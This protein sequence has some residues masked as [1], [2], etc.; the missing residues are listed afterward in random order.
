MGAQ[1]PK[2]GRF[3]FDSITKGMYENPLCIFR[4]YIQNSADSLDKAFQAKEMERAEAQI[5]IEIKPGTSTITVE[6][7]GPGVSLAE[8]PTILTSIGDSTKFG[9][10]NR[11]FRGIGRLGG[12][13]YCKE[14]AFITK[15]RGESEETVNRWDCHTMGEMLSPHSLKHRG[16]DLH[17]VVMTCSKF[18]VRPSKR[19]KGES[20]FRVEMR[21][22]HSAKGVLTDIEAVRAYL[23]QVAPLPFDSLKFPFGKEIDETLRKEVFNYNTYKILVNDEEL[24]KPYSTT[25]RLSLN[26]ADTIT[27]VVPIEVLDAAGKIIGRGWRAE[28]KDLLGA[29]LR[30]EGVDGIRV[31]V[32]N[33]LLGD[34]DL[35][36]RVF[37]QNRFNAYFIGEIHAVDPGLIPNGRRDDFEP[38][39]MREVFYDESR[40]ALGEPLSKLVQKKSSDNSKTKPIAKAKAVYLEV[41]SAIGDGFVT[42]S[43][44]EKAV[45]DLRNARDELSGLTGVRDPKVRNAAQTQME[46]CEV[47]LSEIEQGPDNIT[48]PLSNAYSHQER[49][50]FGQICKHICTVYDKADDPIKLCRLVLQK[51]NNGRK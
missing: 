27:G 43:H 19:A 13:A 34:H 29:I 49:E 17:D 46:K 39:E 24:F 44:K 8:A 50:F 26:K 14:I 48:S 37:R 51:M 3:L 38:S 40:K 10:R 5:V 33:I 20:F 6:D 36:D 41:R 23:S 12:M 22:V 9:Q 45:Q 11:G 7:N 47:L 16:S 21:G 28:R 15:A 35:L 4:E 31:R 2:I 18:E 1:E 30:T 42:D 25:V 32:G